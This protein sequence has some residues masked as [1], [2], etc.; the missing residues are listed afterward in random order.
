[1]LM[2]KCRIGCL[3]Q[4]VPLVAGLSASPLPYFFV[5]KGIRENVRVLS[6]TKGAF[7]KKVFNW[8][9][10]HIIR[11]FRINMTLFYTMQK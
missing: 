7:V 2:V 5:N 1:M 9:N 4:K 11:H 3:F 10:I 8:N 6:A